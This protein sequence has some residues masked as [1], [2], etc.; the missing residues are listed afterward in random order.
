[1][2]PPVPLFD[3]ENERVPKYVP[4]VLSKYAIFWLIF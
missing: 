4:Q 2:T 1:M 3:T